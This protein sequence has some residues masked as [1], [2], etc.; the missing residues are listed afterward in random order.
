VSRH[1]PEGDDGAFPQ[2]V[3]L[4]A[5]V[6]Q[7]ERRIS[8]ACSSRPGDGTQRMALQHIGAGAATV[9]IPAGKPDWFGSTIGIGRKKNFKRA[10]RD[11][12]QVKSPTS[13]KKREM[14]HPPA[15]HCSKAI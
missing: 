8:P 7:A 9:P 1:P 11:L 2:G 3:I 14:G 5:A 6:L 12:I 4:S 15:E 13:R 10:L